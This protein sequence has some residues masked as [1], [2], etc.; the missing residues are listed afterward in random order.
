MV[1]LQIKGLL[2][3]GEYFV[4]GVDIEQYDAGAP[5][6]YLRG[7][8]LDK[9][10]SIADIAFKSYLAIFPSAPISFLRFAKEVIVDLILKSLT[11]YIYTYIIF[12]R[13]TNIWNC[14]HL[15]ILI[16]LVHLVLTN[17]LLSIQFS[18]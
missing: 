7:L 3:Q 17:R 6:K 11:F 4:V 1:S 12:D 16:H 10:D 15:I 14:H 9:I 8:L 5:D 13:L 2:E 18:I